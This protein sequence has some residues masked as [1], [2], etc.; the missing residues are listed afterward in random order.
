MTIMP[1]VGSI[2]STSKL[3]RTKYAYGKY[4]FDELGGAVSAITLTG[5]TV[6]DGAVIL[7]A[8]LLVDTA[9]TSG[10]AGTVAL[11]VG[12]VTL[13]AAV[14][15]SGAPYSSTGAKRIDHTRAAVPLVTTSEGSITA[16]VATAALTAGVFRVVV[17]YLEVDA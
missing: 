7:D 6:P 16:T 14:A 11:A 12:G 5:D 9:V 1:G 3:G 17:E 4:D 8:V 2:G 13:D 10:G 15:V